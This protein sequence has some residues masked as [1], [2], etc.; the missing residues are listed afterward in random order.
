MKYPQGSEGLV[1][2][3]GSVLLVNQGQRRLCPPTDVCCC[4][5]PNNKGVVQTPSCT[6]L[7]V[8]GMTWEKLMER[9]GSFAEGNGEQRFLLRELTS[10]VKAH[11]EMVF[12]RSLA[13]QFLLAGAA[14]LSLSRSQVCFPVT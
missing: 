6:L 7:S 5:G 4:F 12:K 10:L 3:Q 8:Y 9:R 11:V 2:Q 14:S 1:L 13:N